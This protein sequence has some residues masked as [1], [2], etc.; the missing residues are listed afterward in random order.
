[1]DPPW[2]TWAKK[3][4]AI[5]QTGLTYARDPYD[6]ERYTSVRQVAAEMMALVLDSGYTWPD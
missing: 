1:M 2:L 6:R 5:A 4:Q 3:L